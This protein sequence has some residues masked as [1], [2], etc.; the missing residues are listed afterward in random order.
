MRSGGD[1]E[2]KLSRNR[3]FSYIEKDV[4]EIQ[5]VEG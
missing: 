4:A 2:V 1:K 3:E 5:R